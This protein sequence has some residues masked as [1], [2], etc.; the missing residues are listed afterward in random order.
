MKRKG[1]GAPSHE[2][3][4]ARARRD[5]AL[6]LMLL[7]TLLYFGVFR[8]W[9]MINMRLAFYDYRARGPWRFV[10][11]KHFRMIAKSAAFAQILRNTLVISFMKYVLLFPFFVLFALLLNELRSE[12]FRKYVQAVSY[13]PHFLSWVVIAGIWMSFLAPGGSGAFNQ[14]RGLFGLGPADLLTDKRAIRWILFA[15]E[16]WRSVGWDSIIFFTAILGIPPELY[17]AAALDGADRAGMI[18]HIILPALAAPM[19]T[20]FI[21]NLGFFMSAGFDQVYNFSNPAVLSVV[22]ILDTYINRVGIEG[23][24]YSVG[25]AVSLIKG[26]AGTA[27]VLLTHWA[28]KRLTGEGVW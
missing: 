2:R 13:L 4:L 16:G 15:S 20:V 27:L 1:R 12:R 26:L 17:E 3:G 25:T 24:Q 23:A 10:G 11:L 5:G 18:R 9:P 28:S 8:V 21:L 7:P 6:Y 14:I 19:T 22:D